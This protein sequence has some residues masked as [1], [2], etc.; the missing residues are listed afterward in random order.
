MGQIRTK[1]IVLVEN[2]LGDYDKIVT[3]LT[4]GMGKISCVAK[5]A[6][7]PKSL[8]MAGTQFLC[9]ADYMMYKGNN[10]YNIKT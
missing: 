2:N 3:M 1:G 7:R 5:G 6:R 4:P 8:L 9:F 10:T